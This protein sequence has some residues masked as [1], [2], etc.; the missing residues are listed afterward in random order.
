MLTMTA[1]SGAQKLMC[2]QVLRTEIKNMHILVMLL[3][4]WLT[5][6]Y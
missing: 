3:L 6:R 4:L 2:I 1:N 5:K